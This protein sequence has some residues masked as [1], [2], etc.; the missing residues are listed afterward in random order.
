M[1]R[2]RDDHEV[3]P[4]VLLGQRFHWLNKLHSLRLL[5]SIHV[6]NTESSAAF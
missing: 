1:E 3:M 5:G 2:D 4:V 6:E